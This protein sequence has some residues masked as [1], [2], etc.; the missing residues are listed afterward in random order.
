M[1][2]ATPAATTYDDIGL[3]P[4]TSYSYT[5][6][7]VDTSDNVSSQSGAVATTTLADPIIS[8]IA[9]STGQT[10]A[11]VTWTTD[12]PSGSQVFY[13]TTVSYGSASTLSSTLV[14]SHSVILSGLTSSTVYHFAAVSAD[15]GGD[16]S[17][18]TDQTLTTTNTPDT[19]P[20]TVAMTAP[21]NGA[22]VSGTSVTASANASDNVAVAGVTFY[23]NGVKQGSEDTSAPYSIV[24]DSTATS[25]GSKIIFAVARD[26]SNNY[27]TSSSITVTDDNTPPV[28]S[29]I[30]SSTANT[31]ATLTWTT[32]E[33]SS[34]KVVWGTTTSYGS[35]SST[36]S[37]VTSHSI[38]LSGLSPSTTYHFAVVSADGQGN[39][40]TSTDQ[41]FT[42]ASSGY[43][44]FLDTYSSLGATWGFS[45]YKLSNAYAGNWGS[46]VRQSDGATT[47]IG[48]LS[49]GNVNVAAFNSFCSNTNCYVTTLNDQVNGINATQTTFSKMPRVIVDTNGTLAVCPQP[50]SSMATSYSSTVN[51][52]KVQ[53]FA[54]AQLNYDD[55]RWSQS[56]TPSFSITGNVSN[57]SATITALSTEV[58]I[59]T[60]AEDPSEPGITDS[61][62]FL[63][64]AAYISALPSGSTATVGFAPG[65]QSPTGSQNGDTLTVHNAVIPGAWIV[66]GPASSS[67]DSTAYW[68]VGVGAG[69]DAF[70]SDWV[71]PRNGTIGYQSEYQSVIGQG[72]RG[73]WAVYD[74][75]TNTTQLDYDGVSLG[76][77]T[78]TTAN[79][80]YSTNVGMSLFSD[81]NGSESTSNSCFETMVLFPNT[82]ASR[83]TMA[84]SLMTEDSIS[85]PFATSTTDG[86]NMTA[87]YLPGY[88]SAPNNAF[89]S[90]SVGPDVFGLTWNP[91]SG[92]YTW[93][94]IAYATNIGNTATMWRF[95]DAPGDSDINITEAERTEVAESTVYVTPGNSFSFFY[96]FDFEQL[97][98]QQG[99]WCYTAQIHYN[100]ALSG[101]DAP[102]I[103]T[104]SCKGDQGQFQTQRT[105]SGNPVVTNCGS[106]FTITPGT[107]YAVVGTGFW[108]SNHT[109]D[110]LTINAGPN[111]TT[112]PQI[113]SVGPTTLW[114]ND[115]GA[116]LKAGIYRG[117]PWSNTGT[118]IERVMSPQITATANAFSSYI[119]TQPALPTVSG[120]SVSLTA[121]SNGATV[122]GSSVT[123]SATASDSIGTITQVKFMV[124][125]TTIST[126][127]SSP[128]SV[129]WDSTG[130]SDG[131]HTLYAVALDNSSLYAT[132]SE[133]VTVQNSPPV[134]SSIS[135]GTPGT[136]SAIVTW[137]TNDTASSKVV[138]GTTAGYGSASS[139]A[140]L[141]TS[142]S[143]SLSGLLSSTTYHY[144]VVSAD[145]FGNTS[146]SSDQTFTTGTPDTTP[147]SAP[148]GLTGIVST[149]DINL[150]WASSTDNVAVAFY[151]I[152]RNST[153]LASTSQ[154]T[155]DD[156]GLLANT[157]YSY[158]VTAVDTSSN[159]S[160]SS[161]V[162]A[163]TTLPV[164]N[165]CSQ[166]TQFLSRVT[167][168]ATHQNAY[169]SLICGLVGDGVW[170]KL[171]TLY[172]F[173]TQNS[174]AALQNLVS[175]SFTASTSSSPTFTADTGY[176]GN[177]SSTYI[178]S[179]YNV[180]TNATNYS[181][182]SA[183]LFAWS[184]ETSVDNGAAVGI[185]DSNDFDVYLQ[186]Y[187]FGASTGAAVNSGS[188]LTESV[189]GGYS[190]AGA[191]F[192]T[193]SR[194]SGAQ[195]DIYKN[196]TDL[197]SSSSNTSVAVP[198]AHILFLAGG[199]LTSF[200]GGNLAAGGDG[201]GLTSSDVSNLYSLLHS[202]LNTVN[203][204]AFP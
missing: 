176:A 97:P 150:S 164:S 189:P 73:Q 18:S 139:S 181:R 182:N 81:T 134:I 47:T 200:F 167:V 96:Q 100:N 37:L 80:T 125:G 88:T 84:Q 45:S 59:S 74:Y 119:T 15:S 5:V 196:S 148:T 116:Y 179:N 198:S 79:V 105:V 91:Q 195:V 171:D 4:N 89:G 14:T 38:G 158:Y 55:S 33:N 157:S 154:I 121:P 203:P 7:A 77:L 68:G 175:S 40:S 26:T 192:Y 131:A 144:A 32:D 113:C 21:S 191:G 128:Y 16:T 82:E 62:G 204:T 123:V 61:G 6:A 147:P 41:T 36:A 152:Y 95:I 13:G 149:N 115:T 193:V 57:G 71:A 25:S 101:A 109:S 108:S 11:T 60:A 187:S 44:G 127:S 135:S 161:T 159:E 185:S 118:I 39:T 76:K 85:F 168:D 28:I 29:F 54:V 67:Y 156:S 34:S 65:D 138:Y 117:Y 99:D 8:S 188:V 145:T 31:T 102:D 169:K 92:G 22:T 24:W 23:I 48:F 1:Q 165:N 129:T 107:T 12:R 52:P 19:T 146:T 93:P 58:G 27:A 174:G 110:T 103:V 87:D 163:T 142:H 70:P 172:V 160:A 56:T 78:N 137:T 136:T 122:H 178:D 43:T 183:S 140:S 35:S 50:T 201:A 2:I 72:M 104:L 197:G 153:K 98:N 69:D 184:T 86:F 180:S 133:S 126:D 49:N 3:T 199:G 10:S 141:V 75:D 63:P 177:G 166:G 9:S 202:F 130:V 162:F 151:N 132:S 186:P 120:P 194:T 53:V 124:D 64:I 46:I 20:P 106:P 17:T 90:S 155:Y 170:S 173:A 66:N 83:T 111:G 112:L 190:T 143:I 30:A 94:S 114:D 42:T 51:T